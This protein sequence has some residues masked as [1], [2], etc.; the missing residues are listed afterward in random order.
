VTEYLLKN[1]VVDLA[2]AW[3]D[4]LI[5]TLP[6]SPRG[7][8]LSAFALRAWLA[9]IL[10]LYIAYVL[11]LESP[12]WA[13]LTVWIVA[14]PTPGM[15]LS[16]SLFLVLG[17]FAGGFFGIALIALFA[18][19]PELFVLG[20]GLLVGACTVASNSLTNFRAYGTV[21]TGYT[22]GLIASG[23]A[24][25][26]DQ[27][28]FIAMARVSCILVGIACSVFVV[29]IFAPHRSAAET[30]KKLLVALQDAARRAVY[31][32][33]ADNE[34]RLQIG[35]KLIFELIALNTL[36]EFAAA[37]SAN[38]RLQANRARTLLSHIFSL[39]SA[40][41]SLDAHLERRGW[42][43]HSGL[44]VFHGVIIDFLNEMPDELERGQIDELLTGLEDVRH[45]LELLQP[46][47]DTTSSEDLVSERLVIDRLDDLL[48]HL[49]GALKNWRD[50][51]QGKPDD[52]PPVDINFHRDLRAA[53]INGLRAFLAINFTGAFWIASAWT[54]G[55]LALVFVS[56]LMSLFSAQPHPDRIGWTFF[57]AGLIACSIG[58]VLKYYFLPMSS[59]F[60][61][62]A[63][64]LFPVLFSLGLVMGT[65]NPTLMGAAGGFSFV[66]VNIIRPFNPMVYDLAD[67]LNIGVA[68]QLGILFGTLSY[69]L[70]F[71]PDP[72][73]A[74]RYVTHRIRRGL[75][76]ISL[77][78]PVPA[79]NTH[80]ETRMYD[81]VVRLNDPQNPSA[82]MTDEW[83]DAGL[84]ALT[85][86]NEIQRLRRWLAA[87]QLSPELTEAIERIINAF[88]RFL[89]EPQ[90][91][92]AEVKQQIDRLSAL[93]PA[94]GQPGRL[95][96][97]R[98]QGALEEIDIYLTRNPILTKAEKTSW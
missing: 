11:Q 94:V 72:K 5:Q 23:A 4:A 45:Q 61:F 46:E 49:H 31:S 97:A 1:P 25:A 93:A 28:F 21:L 98:V 88:G 13:W 70:I 34:A 95:L 78:E 58:L 8:A 40:R 55:S 48:F 26:P 38:F 44:E 36:I 27:V 30:R 65:G 76:L 22:A 32:W 57:K 96:W 87:G 86:G 6:V 15:L 85:L 84:G 37:E 14:Q 92:A 24:N 69:L 43:R 80:W 51:L 42:P 62:L 90:R 2:R 3:R 81:R 16:K 74:R 29:S 91:A 67:T 64:M 7:W 89:K 50:I 53:W 20:L 77:L 17:T 52:D 82:N 41:R 60:E 56:V 35:R 83:L 59:G 39:I 73:A 9:S 10:A 63:V 18:Q 54:E 71:P 66:F 33:Q 12:Y 19:A 79:S 47:Q 68:V 75:G